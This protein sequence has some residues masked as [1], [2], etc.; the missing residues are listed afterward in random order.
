MEA[1]NP[2][3]DEFTDALEGMIDDMLVQML[4]KRARTPRS[5]LGC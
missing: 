1:T 5:V 4:H 2:L 3:C